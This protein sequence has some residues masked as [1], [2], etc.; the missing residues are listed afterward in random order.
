MK[1]FL[2]QFAA[3]AG[4]IALLAMPFW[5]GA[6][7]DPG[8]VNITSTGGVVNFLLRILVLLRTIFWILVVIFI[9]FAA[10][11]YLTAGGDEEKVKKANKMLLYTVIAIVVALLATAIPFLVRSLITGQ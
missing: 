1:K 11:Y 2:M 9:I 5:A 8:Q 6:Q 4:L 3:G 7:A 10:F